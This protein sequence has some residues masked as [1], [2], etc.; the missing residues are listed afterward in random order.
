MKPFRTDFSGD[1]CR[2]YHWSA[3]GIAVVMLLSGSAIAMQDLLPGAVL[4]TQKNRAFEPGTVEIDKGQT[5]H[6]V[7]DDGQLMH[8]AY[9]ASSNFNF[10]SG[11][12]LPGT[13]VDIQF[14]TLGKYFVLCGI[15]P[16][17]RLSVTVR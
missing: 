17:M 4:I 8:H 12:Q 15:H 13:A 10:D 11:E 1:C 5:L 6:I 16:K 9:V 2:R 3:I 7:N 14:S